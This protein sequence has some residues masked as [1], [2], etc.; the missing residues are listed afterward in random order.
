[1][2]LIH[3][4][5][6]IGKDNQGAIFLAQNKQVNERTKHIDI[7]HY[8]IREFIEPKDGIQQGQIF[9]VDTK[10]NTVDIGTKTPK[11]VC[12]KNM[13]LNWIME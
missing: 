11:S 13:S 7:K 5:G 1:M 12:F 4:Q 6:L 10:E 8:F 2:K 9:K 3:L